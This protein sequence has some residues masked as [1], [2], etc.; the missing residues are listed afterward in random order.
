MGTA[1]PPARTILARGLRLRCPACGGHPIVLRWFRLC[2]SCPSCGLHLDRDEPGY[3]LG[4]Y[5]VNLF[6][7][8]GAFVTYFVAA[9]VVTWPTV[10][11]TLV[12][13]GGVAVG[14][15]IP[16]LIFPFT[17]TLYLAIDL[18]LRPPGPPDLATP[19]ERGIP[20]PVAPTDPR[21][22]R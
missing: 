16:F 8:E 22:T 14:L 1:L 15:V 7:T 11:W 6:A 12:L 9:L 4:S 18:C 17:K 3:W 2:S 19:V 21:R 13:W 10:P 5:T 20:K